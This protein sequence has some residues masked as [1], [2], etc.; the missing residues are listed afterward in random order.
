MITGESLALLEEFLVRRRL[1]M[2]DS[3]DLAARKVD[4]FL[5]LRDEIEREE[6]DGKAEH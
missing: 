6:G 4:A 1:G 2:Q 3:M 5:I